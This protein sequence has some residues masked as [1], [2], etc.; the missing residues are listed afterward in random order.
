M[1]LAFADNSQRNLN[2]EYLRKTCSVT[3]PHDMSS[4]VNMAGGLVH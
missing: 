4:W 1:R 3:P 2:S